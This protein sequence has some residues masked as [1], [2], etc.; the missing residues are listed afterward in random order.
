MPRLLC[1]GLLWLGLL[2]GRFSGEQSDSSRARKLCGRHL[3]EGIVKLCGQEDWSHFQENPPFTQLLSQ[4]AEKVESFIPDR[5]ESSQTTFPVWG[6]G[7]NAGK[8]LNT[9]GMFVP[10]CTAL[11]PESALPDGELP[12]EMGFV[13]STQIHVYKPGYL[14]CTQGFLNSEKNKRAHINLPIFVRMLLL[15]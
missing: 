4:V 8:R 5:L 6:R 14:G 10:L 15:P 2:P 7:T 11:S 3:L 13:P 12:Q 9:E 1:L